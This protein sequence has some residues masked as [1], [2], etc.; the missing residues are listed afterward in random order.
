MG[1]PVRLLM[2]KGSVITLAPLSHNWSQVKRDRRF[3]EM[4]QARDGPRPNVEAM[5]CLLNFGK[6]PLNCRGLQLLEC[7]GQLSGL[8]FTAKLL[9][10]ASRRSGNSMGGLG[11]MHW[12][13]DSSGLVSQRP[14]DPLANPP[15][16]VGAELETLAVLE[17][18]GRFHQ[19][20]I[21]FLNQIQEG[22]PSAAVVLGNVNDE[23]QI[24]PHQFVLGLLE[25]S[26]S[27]AQKAPALPQVLESVSSNLARGFRFPQ[28]CGQ[29]FVHP[30][31][32]DCR[33][34]T[35]SLYFLEG[36]QGR[37]KFIRLAHAGGDPDPFPEC[38]ADGSV[39]LVNS[40][41]Q[42]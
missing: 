23:A 7:L 27:L 15:G 33:K 38:A 12:H 30:I 13:S 40:L 29:G 21:A 41:G 2:Q 22:Q 24:A 11:K 17:P 19:A 39:S 26:T 16:R 35:E 14:C 25:Q 20:H 18:F 6:H 28:Q 1:L 10:Q 37:L 36:A 8:R 34:A 42:C 32:G 4:K 5:A 9:N 3:L 31:E